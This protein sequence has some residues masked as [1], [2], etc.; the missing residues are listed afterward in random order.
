[1]MNITMLATLAVQDIRRNY[2]TINGSEENC[3]DKILIKFPLNQW[4]AHWDYGRELEEG[5]INISA[6]ERPIY[7]RFYLLVSLRQIKN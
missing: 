4:K 2:S 6:K 3:D 5:K 7:L 1:M